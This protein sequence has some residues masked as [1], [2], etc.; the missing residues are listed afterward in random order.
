MYNASAVKIYNATSSLVRYENIKSFLYICKNALAYYNAAVV[1]VNSEV[2]GLAPGCV[3][4][5]FYRNRISYFQT[6]SG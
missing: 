5:W 3:V 6:T 4:H 1:V 2:V